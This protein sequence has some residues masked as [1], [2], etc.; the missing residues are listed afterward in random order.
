MCGMKGK[1]HKATLYRLAFLSRVLQMATSRAVVMPPPRG[2]G[3]L[4]IQGKGLCWTERPENGTPSPPTRT[5]YL[6][7][8]YPVQVAISFSLS[9]P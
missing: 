8:S 2:G 1:T 7:E 5:P 3:G 6:A 9:L 4:L